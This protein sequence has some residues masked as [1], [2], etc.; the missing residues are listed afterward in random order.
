MTGL[1]TKFSNTDIKT[2]KHLNIDGYLGD[3]H[4]RILRYD[5]NIGHTSVIGRVPAR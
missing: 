2:N 5:V 4:G 3:A 1:E